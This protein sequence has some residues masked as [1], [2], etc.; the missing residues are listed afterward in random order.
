MLSVKEI[1]YLYSFKVLQSPQT[2]DM[3]SFW[4]FSTLLNI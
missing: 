2:L 1:D 4:L 3:N